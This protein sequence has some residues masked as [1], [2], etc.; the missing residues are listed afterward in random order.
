MLGDDHSLLLV[1]VDGGDFGA[2]D[3]GEALG[4]H[5]GDGALFAADADEAAGLGDD[6][7]LF[8]FAVGADDEIGAVGVSD[9]AGD[10]LVFLL[11]GGGEFGDVL[12]EA[13]DDDLVVLELGEEF[14]DLGFLLGAALLEAGDVGRRSCC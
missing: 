7:G 12:V 9:L 1:D 11:V 8:E 13:L 4:V 3:L 5:V 2:V 6:A 14:G 10:V